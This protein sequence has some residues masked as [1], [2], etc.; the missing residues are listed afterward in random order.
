MQQ[1]RDRWKKIQENKKFQLAVKVIIAALH[2]YLFTEMV[3]NLGYAWEVLFQVFKDHYLGMAVFYFLL[4]MALL[5]RVKIWNPVNIAFVVIFTFIA[6]KNMLTLVEMPDLYNATV[7]KW[8]CGGMMCVLLIDML[9]YKKIAKWKERNWVATAFYLVPAC[10]NFFVADGL[11]YTYLL[12]F[13]FLCLFLLHIEKEKLMRWLFY[14]TVGYYAAFLYTMIKS[15]ITVPYTGERY[16]GIYINHGFFG[17]F[18]GGA[19]VCAL[20]WLIMLIRKKA[21]LWKKL[22]MLLPIGFAVVCAM[23][24]S[25]RVATLAIMVVAFVAICI[26]GGEPTA[27][28]VAYRFVVVGILACILLVVAIGGMYVLSSYEKETLELIID[29]DVLREK[30]IYWNNRAQTLFNAESKHGFFEAGSLL[31]A[32]DRFSSDRLSHWVAYLQETEMSAETNFAITVNGYEMPHPHNAYIYWLYGLGIIP[33]VIMIVWIISYLVQT[34]IQI[35]KKKDVYIL[36]FLWVVYFMT[37]GIN[38]SVNWVV[39]VGF[40]TLLLYYPLIMKY[41]EEEQSCTSEK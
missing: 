30:V 33:G 28:K 9:M 13:P 1:L 8:M 17:I 24:N 23:M 39:P 27:K 2:I 3:L 5:Q 35:F 7:V 11:H 14:L 32:I 31:N 41:K 22:L 36:S 16:Y 29:N 21:P 37:A 15:F 40:I 25:A 12:L 18:I 10:V 4:S 19:F 34:V 20:W 38:E 26:W 6:R